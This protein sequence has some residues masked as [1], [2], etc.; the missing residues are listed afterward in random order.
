MNTRQLLLLLTTLSAPTLAQVVDP[1]NVTIGNVRL[2]AASAEDDGEPVT[3]VIRDNKLEV[4]TK[5]D[6]T[7]GESGI[8]VDANGGFLL[9]T[10]TI[11]DIPSFIILDDDPRTN[12]EVLIDTESHTVFAVSAG[13]L[14]KNLLFEV[15][16]DK[17]EPVNDSNDQGWIAYTPPPMMLPT[18]YAAGDKWNQWQSRYVDGIFIAGVVLDRQHWLDQDAASVQQ[19]GDLAAFDGGEIRGF[20]L[21]AAGTINFDNPWFYTVFGATNA[22]EKGF[23]T[24][25][26][27]DFTWFDYRVDIPLAKDINLSIGKQKEPISMERITSMAQLPMQERT[28]VSDA[29]LPARNFGAVVSGGALQQ[30]MTWAGGVFNNF[31]DSD[32]SI[33]GT[34]SQLIGRTTWLPYVSEDESN[35]VHLGAGLRLDDAKQ[36]VRY[37]TEPE[38]N[39]SPV[40]V[41]TGSGPDDRID[42]DSVFQY[43]LEAAWRVGPYSISSEYVRTDVDSPSTGNP[44]F[45]GFHISGSWILSGEMRSYNKQSGIWG[46]VPVAK[47]VYQGGWGA[48]EAAF[49]YSTLDLTDG[50]IDGGEMDIWSLGLNW[51]LTPYFEVNMNYRRI[52]LDRFGIRGKSNGVMGRVVLILE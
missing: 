9:G 43:N 45:S 36:G 25:R 1:Q 20:R 47:S 49:R 46:P 44:E 33:G 27:D 16:A 19:V 30:R 31:I 38:F 15:A 6:V 39:S 5:D 10:L 8:L 51:W 13:E 37:F 24:T 2:V 42:A 3:V 12:F 52:T 50:T 4:V 18:S 28:S 22:F 35:I 23:D 29:L 14:R 41:D 11:G 48:W 34:S 40:F 21:G 26:D 32:E 17:T 7:A